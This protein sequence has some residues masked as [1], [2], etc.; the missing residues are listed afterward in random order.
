LENRKAQRSGILD[1]GATSGA[2]PAEDEEY[3]DDTGQKSSKIFMLPDKRRHK[4]T[5]KMLLQQPLRKLAR[6]MNIVPGLHSTLISIPKLADANYTTVF[7]KGKA[8]IYDALM[9]MITTDQ[10]PIL[11]APRCK[12]TGLWELPLEPLQT[13]SSDTRSAATQPETINVIFDLPSTRQTLLWYH[14]AAGFPTK[15]TFSDA[16]RAGNYSTWPGLTTK[17]IHHHFPDSNKTV[18]G[19][20]KDQ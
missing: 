11:D 2:A 16:A 20:L 7:E 14:G 19:H 10:P 5:K 1:T 18:R 8:T 3:F 12:L 4:A 17:T 9:T 6:E 15:E 13:T